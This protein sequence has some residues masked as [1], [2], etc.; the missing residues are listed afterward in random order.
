MHRAAVRAFRTTY[1]CTVRSLSQASRRRPFFRHN[2][3]LAQ[4]YRRLLAPASEHGLVAQPLR[5]S[6]YIRRFSVA[7][8]STL[9]GYGAW[10]TYK[11]PVDPGSQ[12]SRS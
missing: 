9:V 5:S 7:L 8:V 6:M 2:P 3:T 12:V 10:Y 4:V 1:Q 11:G